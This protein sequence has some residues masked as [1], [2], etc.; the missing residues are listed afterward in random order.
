MVRSTTGSNMNPLTADPMEMTIIVADPYKAYPAA[1][2]SLPETRA[3]DSS[4]SAL[5]TPE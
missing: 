1:T 3:A 4:S 5:F 2:I